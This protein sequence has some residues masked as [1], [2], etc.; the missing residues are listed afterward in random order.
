MIDLQTLLTYLTLISVPVGVFYHIMTLR[1]TRKNQELQLETRQ[2]QLFTQIAIQCFS[3]EFMTQ[4][5]ELYQWEWEDYEDYQ[6]KYGLSNNPHAYVIRHRIMEL[7]NLTGTMV[8]NDLVNIELINQAGGTPIIS[9]WEKWL[10]V[11]EEERRRVYTPKYMADW[12][13]LYNEVLM[14]RE[15]IGQT[16]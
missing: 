11:I 3:T 6:T 4:Y 13:Y 15:K 14:Y 12:E 8:K 1:N 5:F 10:D 7:F 16:L 9:I 2:A